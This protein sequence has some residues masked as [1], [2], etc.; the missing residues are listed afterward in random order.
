MLRLHN[1]VNARLGKPPI[2][3]EDL[4]KKYADAGC[5]VSACDTMSMIPSSTVGATS[6]ANDDDDNG[7]SGVLYAMH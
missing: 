3:M 6:V 1:K 4:K 7:S 5:D 2:T